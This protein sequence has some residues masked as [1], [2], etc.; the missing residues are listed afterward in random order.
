[1]SSQNDHLRFGDQPSQW[2]PFYRHKKTCR[3]GQ[4]RLKVERVGCVFYR[5]KNQ[6]ASNPRLNSFVSVSYPLI[7]GFKI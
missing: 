1:M 3:L 4:V 5:A 6:L 7:R 2:L